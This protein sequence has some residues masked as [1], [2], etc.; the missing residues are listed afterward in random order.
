M[1]AF[2]NGTIGEAAGVQTVVNALKSRVTWWETR[3]EPDTSVSAAD[4]ITELTEFRTAVLTADPTAKILGPGVVTLNGTRRTW[5]TDFFA[6]GGGALIDGFSFH[7]YNTGGSDIQLARR[8]YDE[9]ETLLTTYGQQ[10]KPRWMTEWG[11]FAAMDGVNVS[12]VQAR[13]TMIATLMHDQFGVPKERTFWFYDRSHGFWT[14]SSFLQNEVDDLYPVA[15]MLRVFAEEV[16]GKTYAA[17]LDFGTVENDVYIGNRYTSVAGDSLAIVSAGRTDGSVTLAVT[18]ASSLTVVDHF[19]NTSTVVVSGGSAT[20]AVGNEPVYVR[21]PSGVTATV[22]PRTYGTNIALTATATAS[23]GSRVSR[24]NDGLFETSY[25]YDSDSVL[26]TEFPHYNATL[27][28]W[29]QLD[30]G[31]AQTFNTVIVH[32]PNPWQFQTSLLDFDLQYW[33]GSTWVTIQTVT[34]SPVSVASMTKDSE[35]GTRVDSFYDE[36][37]IFQFEFSAISTSKL[38]IYARSTSYGHLPDA[39]CSGAAPVAGGQA[40]SIRE[41]QVFDRP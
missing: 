25:Y 3:N 37:H 12:R 1:C 4:Y 24:V 16:L 21:V 40:M 31:G 9:I 22:T 33:N 6:A 35:G 13:Q 41:I 38:R 29:V 2:P 36:Q 19:G 17:E 14:F 20:V 34:K 11:T 39:K 32:C 23:A 28:A 7:D 8:C 26:S 15:T 30:W 18:G 27:P 10:A 5:L